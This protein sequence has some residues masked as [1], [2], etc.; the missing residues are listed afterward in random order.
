M[1]PI[2]GRKGFPEEL[3]GS[4]ENH[5][6]VDI[7]LNR[8]ITSDILRQLRRPGTITGVDVASC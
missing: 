3:G 4:R 1:L 6:A 8:R 5:E 7:A 2:E